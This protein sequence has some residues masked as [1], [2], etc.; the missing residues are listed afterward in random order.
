M[1][2]RLTKKNSI[3]FAVVIAVLCGSLGY[4]VW[5]VNQPETTAP[6][7]SEAAQDCNPPCGNKPDLANW[8]RK[9]YHQ[10]MKNISDSSKEDQAKGYSIPSSITIPAGVSGEIVLYYKSIDS[11]SGSLASFEF[12]GQPFNVKS[13]DGNRR[14]IIN[15]GLHVK[16][17][18]TF[19]VNSQILNGS[20]EFAPG[21]TG[22]NW[23]R[24]W[25]L[26]W[27]APSNGTCGTTF[28]GPP[29]GGICAPFVP[30]NVSADISWATSSGNKIVSQ[31]CWGDWMEWK[32]DYDFNDYLLIVTVKSD[33]SCGDGIVGNTEGEECDPPNDSCT[34]DGHSG[35]CSSTCKCVLDPYCGDQVVGTGEECD[36]PNNPCTKDGH[37]GKCSSTC[38]CILDPYCGDQVVG[39]G[40]EC[41]PPN[42]SCTKDGHSGKC[43]STCKCVLD[44]YCGDQVVG[45][46]E[47]CDPP[48]NPCTKDGHSGKC[49]STCKCIL[50]P[51]CGDQVVGTG[52]ECDPP[53]SP[54]TKDGNTG[55]CSNTCKCAVNPYCGDG[56]LKDDEECEVGDPAGVKCAWKSCNKSACICLP[57]GL[58]I[59]KTTDK[60]CIDEKTENPKAELLYTITVSN[61]G[62][63]VGQISKIE[64][65]LDTKV[66]AA[67]IIPTEITEGGSYLGGKITWLFS[68]PLT[69][70]PGETKVYSYKMMIDKS[71]F[72][73]YANTVVLTPVSGDPIQATATINADCIITVPTVPQTGIFDSTVGR[74]A[75]GFGLIVLGG[76]VYSM[77]S[78]VFL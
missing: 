45:T 17:G 50:D 69:I 56:Q 4:L 18:E 25:S 14:A 16:G 49:S 30:S 52:E 78:R 42:D 57:P 72:G 13:L 39:T 76:F 3:I 40:E 15:T 21:C 68:T 7:E 55:V 66:V 60:K 6:T 70:S 41:D 43:S 65:T 74:I 62:T 35:K 34:K 54:C 2:I 33:A 73:I 26:G 77:P 64:D 27:I 46:G 48:N 61:T 47:E 11:E 8:A 20:G 36:P 53:S 71:H 31:Q 51:Y 59:S 1:A 63:G 32:G 38:K 67:G 28:A 29:Q 19:T 37:S 58:S 24:Y 5:R 12:N 23:N 10:S 22:S 9:P 75:G 44:P